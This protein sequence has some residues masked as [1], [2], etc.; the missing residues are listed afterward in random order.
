MF[1]L[2]LTANRTGVRR[3]HVPVKRMRDQIRVVSI[4]SV[5][6]RGVVHVAVRAG[7]SSPKIGGG[8]GVVLSMCTACVAMLLRV[9]RRLTCRHVRACE[10]YMSGY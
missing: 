1:T 5:Q 2:N 7:P 4:P 8:S 3:H 9:A 10:R 6:L